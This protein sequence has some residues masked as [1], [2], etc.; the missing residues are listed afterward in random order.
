MRRLTVTG[1]AAEPTVNV[2]DDGGKVVVKAEGF[3][4]ELQNAVVNQ[5]KKTVTITLGKSK[6]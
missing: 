6:Q 4:A 5:S 1:F 3:Q 2:P